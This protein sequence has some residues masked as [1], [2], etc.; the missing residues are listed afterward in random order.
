[1]LTAYKLSK[2]KFLWFSINGVKANGAFS[3]DFKILNSL[4][5]SKNLVAKHFCC[6]FFKQFEPDALRSFS[7]GG[8]VNNHIRTGIKLSLRGII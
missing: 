1:M 2:A 4:L 3:D 7:G 5:L 6:M 8:G